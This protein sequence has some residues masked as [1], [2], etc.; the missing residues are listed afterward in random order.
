MTTDRGEVPLTDRALGEDVDTNRVVA[1]Q[2]HLVVGHDRHSH[3]DNAL[4]VATELA[5]HLHAYLHVVHVMDL[6][7]YPIDPDLPDWE[8]HAVAAVAAERE[9]VRLFESG[10]LTDWDFT[11]YRGEPVRVLTSVADQCDALMIIVGTR[12]DVLGP[13]LSRLLKVPSVTRGLIRHNHRPV[14][15]V[16]LPAA[17][18]HPH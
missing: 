9:Q 12:G 13:G 17:P 1:G 14:L 16:P 7:D 6:D 11:T 3:S 5:G 10:R 2:P 15:V 8:E 18:V 4:S